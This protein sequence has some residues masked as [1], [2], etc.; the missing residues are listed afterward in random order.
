MDNDVLTE[1]SQEDDDPNLFTEDEIIK[2]MG[3]EKSL[4]SRMRNQKENSTNNNKENQHCNEQKST[5]K[6]FKI[7]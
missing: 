4:V 6:T 1:N 3:F 7:L 5:N 2:E